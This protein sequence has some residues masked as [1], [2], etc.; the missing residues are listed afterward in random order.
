M[1]ELFTHQLLAVTLPMKYPQEKAY[2]RLL[3]PVWVSASVWREMLGSVHG[4][5]QVWILNW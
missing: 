4:P 1:L 5:Y 3:R 2:L